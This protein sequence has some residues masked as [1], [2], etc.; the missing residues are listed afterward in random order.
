MIPT[1]VLQTDVRRVLGWQLGVAL[2]VG[3]LSVL[4]GSGVGAGPAFLAALVGGVIAMLGTMVL[5]YTV[6]RTTSHDSAVQGQLWL[7]GGA[8]VR[9]MMALVLLAVA[10]GVWHLAPLPLLVAFGLAQLA[11]ILPR[12]GRRRR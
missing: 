7:Y 2:M 4:G 9:F 6:G 12:L 10:L 5:G 3:G 8:L 1:V 11:F